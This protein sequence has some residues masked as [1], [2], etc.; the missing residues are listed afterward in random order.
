[1]ETLLGRAKGTALD[2]FV[3]D[4]APSSA[5]QPLST[6]TNQIRCLNFSGSEWESIQEFL[7]VLSG[8]LSLLHTLTIDQVSGEPFAEFFDS[9]PPPS[10]PLFN[11]AVNLKNLRFYSNS[12][13][14]PSFTSFFFPNLVSFDFWAISPMDFCASQLLSF[15]EASP[16][17]RT[18]HMAILSDVSFQGVPQEKIVLLPN[19][20]NFD[21]IIS[22]GGSGYE[23]PAHISCPSAKITSLMLKKDIEDTIPGEVFPTGASWNAI[24]C[25]YTRNPVED[26]TVEIKTTLTTT[27]SKLTF[28]SAGG[29]AVELCFK[30]TYNE[31]CGYWVEVYPPSQVMN[32][33]ILSQTIRTIETHPEVANIKRLHVCFFPQFLDNAD[34][35]WRLLGIASEVERLFR[36]VGPL[37]ELTIYDCDLR[38]YLRSF[39]TLEDDI[40]GSVTFPPTKE[41][42]IS[43]PR[44]VSNEECVAIV[45]LAKSQH[46]V[47]T[48]FERVVFRGERMFPG[49]VEGLRPWVGSVEYFCEEPR[50]G[51]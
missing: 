41:L 32:N 46:G 40:R 48:P 31:P 5:V 29:T 25:Q 12:A 14:S 45:E 6:R 16:M 2:V 3:G 21:L 11:N 1:M 30:A 23:V 4:S 22:D 35:I 39:L 50:Y 49:M 24:V 28:W 20:Q 27:S 42:T 18:V 47:G 8:P 34:E 43:H 51:V 15:L 19:V 33:E 26:V 36:S 7:E 10:Q 9:G 37:D 38:P 17:L 44:N 13:W